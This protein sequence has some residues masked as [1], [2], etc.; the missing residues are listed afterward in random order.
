VP[1][2]TIPHYVTNQTSSQNAGALPKQVAVDRGH[3]HAVGAGAPGITDTLNDFRFRMFPMS[4]DEHA[5]YRA[6][7][8]HRGSLWR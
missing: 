5:A 1:A 4:R 8:R 2:H 7:Q 3:H 6:P